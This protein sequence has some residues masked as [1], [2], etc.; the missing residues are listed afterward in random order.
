MR[1]S[2][3]EFVNLIELTPGRFTPISDPATSNEIVGLDVPT[4]TYPLL[5]TVKS[6][7]VAVAVELEISKRRVFVSPLLAEIASFAHGEVVPMPTLPV[8][9]IR[10]LSAY[11]PE[12]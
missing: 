11:E 5:S 3:L 6:D 2:S 7:V 4:P 10:N 9:E 12:P 1:G 8:P